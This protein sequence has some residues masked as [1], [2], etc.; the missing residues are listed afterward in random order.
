MRAEVVTTA[1]PDQRFT[2]RVARVHDVVDP[3]TRTIRVRFLVDNP[4]GR[5]KPEMFASVVFFLTLA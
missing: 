2:A 5:L 1:Y 4:D 3:T